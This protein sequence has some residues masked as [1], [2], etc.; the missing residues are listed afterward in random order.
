[1][2]DFLK[3][4]LGV[5][6]L[7]INTLQKRLEALLDIEVTDILELIPGFVRILVLAAPLIILGLGL[8]YFLAGPKEATYRAGY[9]FRWGMGSVQAWQW[10]QKFAGI[11]WTVLGLGLMAYTALN[12]PD[13]ADAAL[14][15]MMWDAI[16]ILIIQGASVLVSCAIINVVVFIRFDLRGRRRLSWKELL[17]G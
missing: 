1:M 16:G 17:Q 13:F 3:N 2:E 4:I 9:R 7:N 15:D 12:L 14:A 8:Y 11:A 6:D 5:E 10:M